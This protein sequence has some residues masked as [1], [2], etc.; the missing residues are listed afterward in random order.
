M[1]ILL[2]GFILSIAMVMLG[3]PAYAEEV[4]KEQIKSLDEQVQEIKADTLSIG[5]QMRLLEEKLLYPSSTQVAVFVS[6][7]NAAKFRLD[8]IEIQLDGKPAAQ[9]LY[10]TKELEALQKGGVQRIYAGNIKSGE[11]DL[12]VLLTGK[13]AGG[14][15]SPREGKLQV[16]QGC[17]TQDAGSSPG[18]FR[19]S[20]YHTQGLVIH[21]QI[22]CIA[23]FPAVR[24]ACTRG[25]TATS[26]GMKYLYDYGDAL[27]YAYQ[28]EWFEAIARFDA[29][30]DQSRGLDEPESTRFSA[31]PAGSWV[32]SS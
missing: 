11:H 13:T 20:H 4:S 19:C 32:T 9:H 24:S 23:G 1:F 29:Q 2:R 18:R 12:Q 31:T 26:E 14:S 17:G 25:R 6:L 28:G 10:S 5:T 22:F 16:Q 7:D 3:F 21:V 15:G 27:Y 30:L 8:S